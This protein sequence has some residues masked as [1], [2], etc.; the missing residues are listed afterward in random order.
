MHLSN[1]NN[2]GLFREKNDAQVGDS[3]SLK[4]GR[5]GE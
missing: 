4:G 3:S 2:C 1:K 5:G